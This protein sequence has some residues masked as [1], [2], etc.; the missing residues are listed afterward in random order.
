MANEDELIEKLI[1][2]IEDFERK[3]ERVLQEELDSEDC[4]AIIPN[5][6]ICDMENFM[7]E[8]IYIMGI[9]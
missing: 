7:G 1:S 9:C 5:T 2:K 3:M 4:H 8:S 6:I